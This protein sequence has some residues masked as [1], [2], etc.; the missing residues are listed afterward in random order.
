MR[1]WL[2]KTMTQ[3]AE[4]LIKDYARRNIAVRDWHLERTGKGNA[5]AG[6]FELADSVSGESLKI[7]C[8]GNQQEADFDI[9]C[10]PPQ[11]DGGC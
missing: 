10:T 3:A 11:G 6:H 8:K 4:M 2:T 1:T 9:N 7:P 5:F